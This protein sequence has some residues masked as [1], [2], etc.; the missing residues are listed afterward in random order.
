MHLS[1]RNTSWTRSSVAAPPLAVRSHRSQRATAWSAPDHT[2]PYGTV[3][4]GWGCSRHFVPGYDRTVPPGLSSFLRALNPGLNGAKLSNLWD[5]CCL[6]GVFGPKGQESLAQGLPWETRSNVMSPQGAPGISGGGSQVPRQ[7][8][9]SRH[10]QATAR[11]MLM[12]LQKRQVFLL[13]SS[14]PMMFD[15]IL[16]GMNG[17][18]QLRDAHAESAI[19]LLPAKVV[20]LSKSLVNPGR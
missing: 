3:L 14:G 6:E 7:R 17:F 4:L 20:Q 13:K 8:A 15:L 9:P 1:T 16:D 5:D 19:T 2:V 18:R 11:R 12:P 10:E